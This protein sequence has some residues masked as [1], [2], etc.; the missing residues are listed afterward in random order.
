[1]W[2]QHITIHLVKSLFFTH[3]VSHLIYYSDTSVYFITITMVMAVTG[4]DI[5][6]SLQDSRII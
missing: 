6:T 5:I 1:M 3:L 4:D 2:P